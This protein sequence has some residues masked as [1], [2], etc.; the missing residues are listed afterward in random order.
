M[1]LRRVLHPRLAVFP[2]RGRLTRCRAFSSVRGATDPLRILFCGSDA[3]SCESL[4][5]LHCEHVRDQGALVE[6]LDVMVLPP[7]R[8]GRGLRQL[9]EGK[10]M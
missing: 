5:A 10:G 1:L 6:A 2:V 7:R 9:W 8:T 3:F 4:R